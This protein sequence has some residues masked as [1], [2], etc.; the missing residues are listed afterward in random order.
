MAMGHVDP[1]G[2]LRRPADA[3]LHRLRQEVHRPALPGRARRGSRR[4]GRLPAGQVPHR[5]ATST[6]PEAATENA[7][8]ARPSS[9]TRAPASRSCPNGSLGH[10][11]GEDGVGQVEPR[12]RRRRPG[13]LAARHRRDASPSLVEL[14]RFDT[15]DGEAARRAR[16]ASRC[17]GSAAT[18]S[19]R[20]ST[21]MLAQY[22][23]GRDGLPGD[24]ASGL[25]RR[26]RRRTRRPGR[27]QITGVPAAH[28]RPDRRG[29]SPR[30]RRSPG[31]AR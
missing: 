28:G 10:R 25:R 2:V 15:A 31:A 3:V 11:Y 1:Q 29:S 7:D 6:S 23:V 14:P 30:T 4:T 13:A 16:A 9:S 27:R 21:C 17:A 24:W 8:C 22:G 26:R 20:S 18:W 5:R 19:P 12:P